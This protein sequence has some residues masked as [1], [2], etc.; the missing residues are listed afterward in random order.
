MLIDR[1]SEL[2]GN[3]M[4]LRLHT[5]THTYTRTHTRAHAHTQ[6]TDPVSPSGNALSLQRPLVT[7]IKTAVQGAAEVYHRRF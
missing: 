3:L 1:V 7:L 5:N 6:G 4:G 2:I